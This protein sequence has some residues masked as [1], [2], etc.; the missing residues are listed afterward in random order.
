MEPLLWA[1]AAILIYKGAQE[2]RKWWVETNYIKATREHNEAKLALQAQKEGLKNSRQKAREQN[3]VRV[4]QKRT[5]KKEIEV[6]ERMLPQ[7]FSPDNLRSM[8]KVTRDAIIK[9]AGLDPIAVQRYLNMSNLE[10]ER[11]KRGLDD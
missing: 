2:A 11:V 5:R 9:A 7:N 6:V 3:R 8:N 10:I 1:A 4:L